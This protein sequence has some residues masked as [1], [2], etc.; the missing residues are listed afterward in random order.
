MYPTPAARQYS[1]LFSC[2]HEDAEGDY[3]IIRFLRQGRGFTGK[4]VQDLMIEWDDDHDERVIEV[5]ER[6]L[7]AGLLRDALMVGERK[8]SLTVGI[9]P[10]S[11]GYDFTCGPENGWRR[12]PSILALEKR[13]EACVPDSDP[14][15]VNVERMVT[16]ASYHPDVYGHD[17]PTWQR[18]AALRL[19]A[20]DAR[21]KL[22]VK[23]HAFN[24]YSGWVA[25]E[26]H[27]AEFM[28][29][30]ARLNG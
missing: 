1:V 21:W 18:D 12:H 28:Q 9:D 30:V 4:Q 7:L 15:G 23:D 27:D 20:I 16:A 26:T 13:I 17:E 3:S 6:M 14:W 5:I 29:V 8:G 11:P 22:G 19:A 10:R 24:P 2:I 25:Q